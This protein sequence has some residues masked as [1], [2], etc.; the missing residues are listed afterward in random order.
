MAVAAAVLTVLCTGIL[1][2]A[3]P[4]VAASFTPISGAGST[5]A[6]PA[7]N[8]WINSVRQT[9]VTVNYAPNGS[10]SGRNFFKGGVT[11]WA[12][13]EIPY[14]VQDGTS[15]DPPPTRGYAYL[16]DAAGGTA[17][18]YNLHIGGQQVT[19]M[20]LSGAVIAGI[21]TSQITMWNN[22]LIAADNP[23][24]TLPATPITP[25]VRS[26]GDGSTSQFTQWMSATQSS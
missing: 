17:F 15:F 13:S 11:D 21:F 5:W 9:G 1:A 18:T 8:S 6:Y 10:T 25:V 7:I 19:N 12:Q 3:Q 26:D 23:G 16:P 24:L 4:A 20:R 2:P 22:P 14:G